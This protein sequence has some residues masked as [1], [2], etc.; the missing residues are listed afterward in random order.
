MRTSAAVAVAPTS[1][2]GRP[3]LGALVVAIALL[4]WAMLALWNASPYGRYLDHGG[5]LD[6]G[7]FAAICSVTPNGD[8]VVPALTHALAWL[9][10]IAAMMLPTTL[11]LLG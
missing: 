6:A 1:Q 7:W 9:L 5:W 3:L 2:S 11:P 8:L 4:A 10:M